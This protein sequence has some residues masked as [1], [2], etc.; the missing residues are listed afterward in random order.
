MSSQKSTLMLALALCAV[1]GSALAGDEHVHG[2]EAKG[3]SCGMMDM[4]DM[5]AEARKSKMDEMFAKLDANK[6]GAISRTE[7]DRHH[8]HMM[9]A[10]DKER[11]KAHDHVDQHK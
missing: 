11:P 3:M 8:E 1:S 6:D 4:H 7:F 5:S 9:A 10:T 2:D